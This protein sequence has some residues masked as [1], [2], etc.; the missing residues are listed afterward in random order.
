M[1]ILISSVN[2]APEPTGIGKYSGQMAAWLAGRGHDVHVVAAPPYYPH[3]RVDRAYQGRGY[4]VETR[5]G[6]RV[7]RA[8]ILVRGAER[9]STA[10]RL[11][12][13]S[14]FTVTS[15]LP[16]ARL[17]W[18]RPRFDVVV[19][20]VPPLQSAAW[21]AVYAAARRIPLLIHVQDLQVDAAV[22]LGFFRRNPGL[23]SA[24][25]RAEGVV[26][27]RAARV[28]TVTEQM[29]RRIVDKGVDSGRVGVF[30]NWADPVPV[31]SAADA[32]RVRR[33]LGLTHEDVLVLY[34]GNMGEKQGLGLVLD[35]AQALEAETSIKFAFFGNGVAR[36]ALERDAVSRHLA[37]V[38]FNDLVPAEE[39]PALLAAG[40]VHL[41]PQRRDAADLLMPSKVA[42]I[43]SA[44]RPFI[45]TSEDGT[46]LAEVVS[47]SG[48]GVRVPP[49]D[50]DAF[51]QGIRALAA[52]GEGRRRMGNQGRAY[53]SEVLDRGTILQAFELELLTLTGLA[54]AAD[55]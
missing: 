36:T 31:G 50:V 7:H 44:G 2:Y 42:N 21:P 11:L 37:N 9:V 45:A 16:W 34:S 12:T 27:R 4:A 20:V 51:V 49:D 35:A 22:R 52:D 43:L 32:D 23:A 39:L 53:A 5:D 24:L 8:P 28:T 41:V 26:L 17:A 14:S 55:S 13:E 47:A 18:S 10:A 46:G 40:D 3:W 25:Y 38:S 19:A 15:T 1:R 6:V 30:Q 54:G 33:G 48:A 29:R